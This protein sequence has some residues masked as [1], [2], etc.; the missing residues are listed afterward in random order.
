MNS[1][2]HF[3]KLLSLLFF[4]VCLMTE[5]VSKEDPSP[6]L[7]G[8]TLSDQS[9]ELMDPEIPVIPNSSGFGITTPAGRGGIIYRVYS[10]EDT[11]IG[12]L[13][14]CVEAVGPR[15]C[16]FETSGVIQLAGEL[17]ISNPNIT[18]AGQ[19]A[20]SPGV[21][22]YGAQMVIKTQDV[23]IQHLGV[24]LGDPL[25]GQEPQDEDVRDCIS[26]REGSDRII[27]DHLSLAWGTDE[28]LSIV[29]NVGE[30]TVS[31]VLNAQPLT[32]VKPG[33][34]SLIYDDGSVAYLG[35]MFA[36]A[37]QR[38]PLSHISNLIFSNNLLY[39]R[40]LR[41]IQLANTRSPGEISSNTIQG[42][43]FVEGPNRRGDTNPI[44]YGNGDIKE[45]TRL[46]LDANYW[47]ESVYSPSFIT[48]QRELIR[49][50]GNNADPIVDTPPLWLE[51]LEPLEEEQRI[52]EY[53][54]ENVGSRP[55]DRNPYDES[56]I[57]DYLNGT[58]QFYECVNGCD[59]NT[60]G[61]PIL[62]VV[63]RKLRIP[64]DPNGDKNQ[65][66]YTNL[67]E[68]LHKFSENVEGRE[69]IYRSIGDLEESTYVSVSGQ[70]KRWH[71]IT[72]KVEGPS[73]SEKA[74]PNP[75]LDYRMNIKFTHLSSNTSIIVPG[76]Y[77][78]DGNAAET[79]DSTGN[80]WQ[81]HF[82]PEEIGS[83]AY[84]VLFEQGDGLA[85]ENIFTPGTPLEAHG[86]TGTFSVSETDKSGND[87]RGK[88]FLRYVGKHHLQFSG[89]K[90]YFIKGGADS[91]ENLLSYRDFDNTPNLRDRQK[92]YEPHLQDWKAGD[93]VWQGTK[94]KGLIGALN[95]L[96][97]KGM[98]AFSFMTMAVNGDD[99]AVYPY[100]IG[101]G[102]D[103]PQQDR[104]QFDVSKLAQ[105]EIVFSHADSL[106]LHLHFKTQET[107]NDILLDGG[108]LGTERKLY[109]RELIAR[110][111]HH[112]ALN[113]NTG[114]EVNLH[115]ELGDVY[116]ELLY[117]YS[118]YIKS[119]DP[120]DH[121]VVSHTFPQDRLSIYTAL[122]GKQS[123]ITGASLQVNYINVH[124]HTLE[125]VKKSKLSGYPWVVAND[126]QGSSTTGITP[127]G[128]GNNH[129]DIRKSVLWGN[130]MA[131]GAG[132]EYYFGY[133]YPHSDMTLQDFRSRDSMWSFTRIAMDFFRNELPFY[134]Y[135]SQDHLLLG[136]GNNDISYAFG[137]PGEQFIV[138]S[139]RMGEL[140]MILTCGVDTYNLRWFNPRTGEFTPES[141]TLEAG[142]AVPLFDPP[143][144]PDEDWVLILDPA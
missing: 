105:W 29:G 6:P 45:G 127:D 85:V 90:E 91:P 47:K 112:L 83:W 4:L 78:A 28:N 16:L 118:A 10:L 14:E 106:G 104:T 1:L 122:L 73:T 75:F 131:G 63:Q 56:V 94:G 77:A 35:N 7:S 12:T 140:S 92:T 64:S 3:T 80:I 62:S 79:S 51:N 88:G 82:V 130:Y 128:E 115:T 86:Q 125:W 2:S 55:S 99:R 97:S 48:D 81:A 46:Y 17:K 134:D 101:N 33:Y 43:V 136:T 142:G 71:N 19:T 66:G 15:V 61:D 68:W 138:F 87:F 32:V 120:Y 133:D 49:D 109:Y 53:V 93:P 25:N 129:A 50:E 132:V 23:L 110:F 84:E 60:G 121:P 36:H 137:K 13:R 24:R 65:N 96:A 41:F 144:D 108:Q 126:E 124:K 95:Y 117:S 54:L 8:S 74:I 98:N 72:F 9:L 116:Q 76:Y 34:S 114:E 100:I 38:Q 42:N 69:L 21:M 26:I 11:G 141:R 139:E 22:L 30:I 102:E 113:W 67:E 58:G 123:P 31:N 135:S 5:G 44:M 39:N 119:L 107:E 52:I 37:D 18:I 20:P 70:Q 111:G 89:N 103:A 57:Q 59:N 27:L 143:S 40:G